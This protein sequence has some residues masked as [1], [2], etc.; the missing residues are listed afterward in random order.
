MLVKIP[1]VIDV[2]VHEWRKM[3]NNDNLTIDAVRTDVTQQVYEH[4]KAMPL[5]EETGA[6]ISV[7]GTS[8]HVAR[9]AEQQS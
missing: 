5:I 8:Y 1:L 9:G 2:D 3:M 7:T 6:G 4:V